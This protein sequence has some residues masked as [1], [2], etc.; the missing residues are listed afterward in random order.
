M[1]LAEE[2]FLSHGFEDVAPYLTLPSLFFVGEVDDDPAIRQCVER[3]SNAT[4][5]SFPG[6]NHADA[7]CRTDLVLPHVTKF[8]EE[9]GES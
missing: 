1:L 6:L 4:Y 5:V 9:V 2:G 8:L 3:M 7:W